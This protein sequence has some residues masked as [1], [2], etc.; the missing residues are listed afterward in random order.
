M[1]PAK[2]DS[3]TE[4]GSTDFRKE[5]PG[6]SKCSSDQSGNISDSS[7]GSE[8]STGSSGGTPFRMEVKHAN[9][10]RKRPHIAAA[11]SDV[12]GGEDEGSQKQQSQHQKQGQTTTRTASPSTAPASGEAKAT[13]KAEPVRSTSV[14]KREKLPQPDGW[15][16]KLYRLNADGSWDD[17][18]TG[19]VLCLYK[20]AMAKANSNSPMPRNTT[21]SYSSDNGSNSSS[22]YNAALDAWICQELGEPTLC[23]HAELVCETTQPRILLRT[24]ILLRDAYQR[25]GENIITW[26]EPY[27]DNSIANHSEHSNANNSNGSGS[28]CNSGGVDLALS[29]QDNAGCLDIWKQITHVQR[30][31]SELYRSYQQQQSSAQSSSQAQHQGNNDDQQQTNN[32]NLNRNLNSSENISKTGNHTGTMTDVAQKVAAEHHAELERQQQH[33]MWVSMAETVQQHSAYTEGDNSGL[34]SQRQQ[35]QDGQQHSAQ[36]HAHHH[37]PGGSTASIMSRQQQHPG[38]S[39]QHIQFVSAEENGGDMSSYGNPGGSPPSH[40]QTSM[41]NNP[42]NMMMSPQL[43][44]PPTLSN[45][46]EIADTFARVQVRLV[47]GSFILKDAFFVS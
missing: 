46:E 16:V 41:G 44:S 28:K 21:S 18:G 45:L 2:E 34:L 40:E 30:R 29:F 35:N 12:L 22:P 43:P 37:G 27:Y 24:R 31:A 4:D 6:D 3:E 15:R 33:Q 47:S 23:M 13:A 17:C 26:C 38:T 25:Q 20:P 7:T 36:H 14:S 5:S 10:K 1:P 32:D 19:R 42:N 9:R 11:S 8:S 39:Q